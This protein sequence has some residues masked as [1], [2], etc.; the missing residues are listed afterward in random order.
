MKIS[1]IAKDLAAVLVVTT[2]ALGAAAP[3]TA[4]TRATAQN[5]ASVSAHQRLM[6]VLESPAIRDA[7]IAAAARALVQAMTAPD[8]EFA[9]LARDKPEFKDALQARVSVPVAAWVDESIRLKR[10]RQTAILEQNLSADEAAKLATFYGSDVGQKVLVGTVQKTDY[11]AT[12]DAAK[13]DGMLDPAA[14]RRDMLTGSRRM[15]EATQFSMDEKLRLLA[16]QADPAFVKFSKLTGQLSAIVV[17]VE[18]R[19][20]PPEFSAALAS[21]FLAVLSEFGFEPEKQD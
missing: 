18:N 7:S 6:A 1:N 19:P 8:P 9:A 20:V 21:E 15:S 2:L 17:E 4:E 16:L 12:I 14:V 5:A 10:D 3:A 13:N 11:A